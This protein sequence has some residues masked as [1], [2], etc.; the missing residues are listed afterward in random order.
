[1]DAGE[2]QLFWAKVLREVKKANH[3]TATWLIPGELKAIY[4]DRIVVA[5]APG[6]EMYLNK[7]KEPEHTAIVEQVLA[8]LCDRPLKFTAKS[9]AKNMTDI[10]SF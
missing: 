4:E 10:G 5:Y 1:M 8:E 2:R 9:A 3:T 7:A 6:D